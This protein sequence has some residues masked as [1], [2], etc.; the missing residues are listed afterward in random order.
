MISA[1]YGGSKEE[2]RQY[3]RQGWLGP[4]TLI[5][6]LEMAEIRQ[7][8]EGY[9]APYYFQIFTYCHSGNHDRL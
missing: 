6:E 7:K 3:H 5:S 9:F 8:I 1:K 2:I 4:F